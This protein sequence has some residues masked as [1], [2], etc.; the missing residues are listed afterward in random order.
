MG[1]VGIEEAAAVGPELL[2][3]DLRGGW[4]YRDHLIRQHRLLGPRL[5]LLVE[6]EEEHVL[7]VPHLPLLGRELAVGEGVELA[8]VEP[9]A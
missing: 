4:A 5:A 6:D 1:R 7:E 2:D 3:R 9:A 8:E